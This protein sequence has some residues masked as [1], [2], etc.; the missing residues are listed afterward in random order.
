M[1]EVV[2]M[3]LGKIEL[4]VWGWDGGKGERRRKRLG[5]DAGKR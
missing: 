4:F 3:G 5:D 2:E 1:I